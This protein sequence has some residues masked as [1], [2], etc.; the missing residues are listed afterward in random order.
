VTDENPFS[1]ARLA[2]MREEIR[3]DGLVADKFLDSNPDV[4]TFGMNLAC[5]WPF[6]AAW[7]E[8]YEE[9]ARKLSALGPE[10]YVY[11]FPC[12]HITLV[13][14]VNFA[15]LIRPGAELVET[16]K[17]GIPEIL[18]T[19]SPLF[20]EHSPERIRSFVLEPQSPVLARGAGLLPMHNPDGEV[21]RLR[22]RAT[23]LIQA[24]EPLHRELMECGFNVPGIIHSTVLRFIRPPADLE[25]L[26]SKFDEIAAESK[27]P[28]L[29]V[30]EVL[31]TSETKPYMRGGE[32]LRRLSVGTGKM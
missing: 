23:E 14:L 29:K 24:N 18:A 4:P 19:L 31:L 9:M 21:A 2:P 28:T 17:A 5:A 7:R 8:S 12:T 16:L 1:P 32:V 11:P 6:P 20:A 3:R 26:L 30:S 13:T 10:V 15:R 22:R 27:F 25:K